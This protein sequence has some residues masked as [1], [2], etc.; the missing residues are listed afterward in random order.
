MLAIKFLILISCVLL[1]YS[2]GYIWTETDK[3]L[4]NYGKFF[5]FQAFKCRKCLSTHIAWVTST[6][7]SLLFGDWI[8]FGVGIAFA[9][10]LFVG[11][12]I[13]ERNKTIKIEDYDNIK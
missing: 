12:R 4:I 9:F 3:A 13:D 7:F 10:A 8:M 1:G 5:D 2:L 11:L 6:F